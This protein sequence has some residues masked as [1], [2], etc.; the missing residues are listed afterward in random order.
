MRVVRLDGATSEVGADVRAALASWGREEAVVGGVAVLGCQPVG[1][2]A[3]DAILLLPHGI[4]VVVGVD[5][6]DPAVTLEAPLAGQWKTDGWPLVREDGAVNPA[7][8]LLETAG[9]IGDHLRQVLVEPLPIATVIAVGPYVSTVEQPAADLARDVR[10]LHPE[11]KTLLTAA[12]ELANSPRACTVTQARAV[13]AALAPDNATIAALELEPEGFSDTVEPEVST[14]DTTAIPK[15]TPPPAALP[16]RSPAPRGGLRWLPATAAVLVALLLL[17]GIVVAV[18]SAGGTDESA[19]DGAGQDNGGPVKVDGVTFV[20]KG[21]ATD[22]DCAA[23][24]S[25]DVQ[26]YL[27]HNRCRELVRMRFESKTDGRTAAVLVAVLRFRENAAAGELHQV[28]DKP[29]GGAIVDGS[30]EGDL[31]P[32][33][34]K[35]LFESAAYASGQEGNSV[36][37]VQV[38]WIGAK[39]TPDDQDL[40]RLAK[41]AVELTAP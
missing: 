27:Q 12:R 2:R 38:V 19:G 18:A 13:L 4:V 24:A 21:T 26:V 40:T 11:P 5:L 3:A 41:A 32:G 15:P 23:H 16:T 33:D 6:P 25:G 10:V 20:P 17:T 39:S 34:H 1:D 29:G 22:D 35:P 31:W 30:V 8:E 37:L 36:K 7:V 14:A 28:A 9:K